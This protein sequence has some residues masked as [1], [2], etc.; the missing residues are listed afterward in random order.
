MLDECGLVRAEVGALAM[1]LV[2]ASVSG[3]LEFKCGDRVADFHLDGIYS[4]LTPRTPNCDDAPSA[5]RMQVPGLHW[6]ETCAITEVGFVPPSQSQGRMAFGWDTRGDVFVRSDDRISSSD[7]RPFA[8][9]FLHGL[10]GKAFDERYVDALMQAYDAD[11]ETTLARRA[12]IPEPGLSDVRAIASNH[13]A[14]GSPHIVYDEFFWY[15]SSEL[16]RLDLAGGWVLFWDGENRHTEL[17]ID[18]AQ[19]FLDATPFDDAYAEA[20]NLTGDEAAGYRSAV[21]SA[22]AQLG[23]NAP[24]LESKPF[25]RF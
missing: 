18:G 10:F 13:T 9:Q 8:R 21:Q 23:L 25:C 1:A 20:S 4:V 16:I 6:N 22:L 24:D 14:I 15:G 17:T 19:V 3:C 5:T 7:L 11:K 2:I 12:S